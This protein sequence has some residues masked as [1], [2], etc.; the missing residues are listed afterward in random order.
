V[1]IN[2]I[3]LVAVWRTSVLRTPSNILICALASTDCC[4]GL[5]EIIFAALLLSMVTNTTQSV[6]CVLA[7]MSRVLANLFAEMSFLTF[8]AISVDK[9]LMLHLHLRYNTLVTNTRVIIALAVVLGLSGAIATLNFLSIKIYTGTIVVLNCSCFIIAFIS[10]TKIYRVIIRHQQEIHDQTWAVAVGC[11]NN[12]KLL[13]WARFKK[14]T[15]SMMFIY[16]VFLIFYFPY[17]CIILIMMAVKQSETV[18]AAAK[19]YAVTFIFLNSMLNPLLICCT[20][21]EIKSAMKQTITK[22]NN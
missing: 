2:L 16:S 22:R 15:F 6:K 19:L 13:E 11:N 10:Y 14:R 7:A 3:L 18:V 1:A 20:M 5:V 9:L 12:D 17:I 21:R 4:V 8:T